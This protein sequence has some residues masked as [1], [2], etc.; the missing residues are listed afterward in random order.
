MPAGLQSAM[1]DVLAATGRDQPLRAFVMKS[2]CAVRSHLGLDVAFVSEFSGG[3]RI[4]RF[5]DSRIQDQPVREGN[6]NPLEDSYCQRV[7][8]GRLPELIRDATAV[9]AALEL[10]VTKA[11]PVGAHLSVPIRL[12]DGTVFG[13]FCCFSFKPDHSLTERDLGIVRVFADLAAHYLERDLAASKCYEEITRRVSRILSGDGLHSVYQPI[14]DLKIGRVNG[15]E[16][17]SRFP[18]IPRQGPDKWF[19]D[20]ASVGLGT[21]LELKA[22]EKGLEA[23]STFPEDVYLSVNVSPTTLMHRRLDQLLA[24]RPGRRIVLEITEHEVVSQYETLAKALRPLRARGLRVAVDD[25]GAGYASFRHIVRLEPDFIKLDMSLT[26]GIDTSRAQRALASALIRFAEET[27]SAIIAEGVETKAEL[28]TL[29]TLGVD[30]AQG[31]YFGKPAPLSAHQKPLQVC[32]PRPE[33]LRAGGT[34]YRRVEGLGDG[35]PA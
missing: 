3:H 1:L 20:A 34:V 32:S 9:P 28:E 26:R 12:S 14:Q 21:E 35:S 6:G 11:L 30:K 7:V 10:P 22:V 16:C 17:L 4:F 31:F 23:L 18:A 27:Q 25:A 8:D 5:V 33:A 24:D 29:R 2:L 19:A 15:F 13:T